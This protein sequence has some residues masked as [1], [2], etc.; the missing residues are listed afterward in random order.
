MYYKRQDEFY[1]SNLTAIAYTSD[2]DMYR[3]KATAGEYSDN[4]IAI[5]GAYYSN[6]IKLCVRMTLGLTHLRITLKINLAQTY[7]SEEI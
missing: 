7:K 3:I 2:G 4:D 6:A 5:E 1:G